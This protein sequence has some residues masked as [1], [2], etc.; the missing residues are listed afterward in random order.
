V[1]CE[2]PIQRCLL[3]LLLGTVPV[4]AYAF[5]SGSDHR[6][7]SG[8]VRTSGKVQAQFDTVSVG[9]VIDD[10]GTKLGFKTSGM[11][12]TVLGFTIFKASDGEKLTVKHGIFRSSEE[13]QRYFARML[14]DSA[15]I[16]KQEQTLD[17]GGA[18]VGW[19]AE[20][21]LAPEKFGSNSS[22]VMWTEGEHFRVIIY[23]VH[24][25]A[26]ELEKKYRH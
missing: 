8:T 7:S 14:A 2:T 17:K 25:D 9:E 3:I 16:S 4:S 22:A 15:K 10:E 11:T 19:R 1:N 6:D 5:Q 13:A 26:L 24:S 20:V 18:S 12:E 21:V 23:R